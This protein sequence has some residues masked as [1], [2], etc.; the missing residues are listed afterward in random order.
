MLLD[1]DSVLA[2]D[3]A[4]DLVNSDDR[5]AGDDALTTVDAVS[6]FVDEHGISGERAGTDTELGALRRLRS[7]LREIFEMAAV[8]DGP[9]AVSA[10]NQLI[11]AVGAVP[12]LVEHDGSPLHLHFTPSDAPLDHRIGAEI[13]V[14]LAIVIRDGGLGRLR[15]CDAPD[16]GRVF[17][18]L[19]RNR[20]R[21]Y[22][23]TLCGNRQ[24]VAAYRH[25]RARTG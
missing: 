14:A 16:C 6:A 4:V 9:G 8:G 25:R 2:V 24:N 13:A 12:Q 1:H 10:V 20:S 15:V 23:D 19:S 5:R 21:R 17:V 7:R 11:A 3:A 22:C 18:D